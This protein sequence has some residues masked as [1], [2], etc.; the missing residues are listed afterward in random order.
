MGIV[1]TIIITV[2]TNRI[3]NRRIAYGGS[4]SLG[5]RQRNRNGLGEYLLKSRLH[6]LDFSLGISQ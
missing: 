1:I 4:V 3:A 6:L 5:Y 2:M